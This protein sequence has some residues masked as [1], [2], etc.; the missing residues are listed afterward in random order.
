LERLTLGC[1]KLDPE[2]LARVSTLPLTR[3][4]RQ[5]TLW[6]SNAAPQFWRQCARSP[7]WS[8]LRGLN[9][10]DSDFDEAAAHPM[11]RVRSWS[12]E[13]LES[14]Y[15]KLPA[16][17]AL[18]LLRAAGLPNLRLRANVSNVGFMQRLALQMFRKRFTYGA[19]HDCGTMQW[20]DNDHFG[21]DRW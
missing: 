17:A 1:C 21:M 5:L 14:Y 15:T 2:V 3:Q 12:L 11:S 18:A 19:A 6:G 8:G 10:E 16:S 9:V 4:L 13:R 7:N 20:I